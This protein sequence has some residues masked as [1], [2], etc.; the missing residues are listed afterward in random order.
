MITKSTQDQQSK[1]P[2]YRQ[3]AATLIYLVFLFLP[4]LLKV[5]NQNAFLITIAS[6]IVFIPLHF[7]SH[8]APAERKHWYIIAVL[9]L[10]VLT[11]PFWNGHNVY[12]I[13]GAAM[14]GFIL[15][16]RNAGIAM[17]LVI[18]AYVITALVVERVIYEIPMTIVIAVMVWL[19]CL[20]DSHENER[21]EQA[22][23][24][25]ALEKQLASIAER[26]RIAADLHDVIGQT[27][28]L[29]AL[30]SDLVSKLID[31]DA[32]RAKR[33][34]QELQ[35]ASRDALTQVR[36]TLRGLTE[37][38][39]AV[40]LSLARK[41]LEASNIVVTIGGQVPD[42]SRQQNTVLGLVIREACTNVVRHSGADKVSIIF[43]TEDDVHSLSI[44]DNGSGIQE[45]NV[46]SNGVGLTSIKKR[47][48]S[49]GGLLTIQGNRGTILRGVIPV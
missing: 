10:G 6:A 35:S 22:E 14:A 15:D 17:V 13:Y 18:A 23:R 37:T 44:E 41:V 38:T 48:S 29:V 28:T 49:L 21:Y 5:P 45:S 1:I 40:E 20:R 36:S 43:E 19:S 33:E 30:K 9:I 24:E 11:A 8:A 39:V 4:W 47:I 3:P 34:M 31:K 42:L 7:K 32:E 12:F 46:A 26:E 2:F 27:L 16:R 25:R